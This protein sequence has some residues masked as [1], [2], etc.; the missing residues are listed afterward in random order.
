M[1]FPASSREKPNAVWVRSFVPKEKNSAVSASSSATTA[2]RGSSIIVPSVYSTFTPDSA[3]TS[4][5]RDRQLTSVPAILWE[6]H[7]SALYGEHGYCEFSIRQAQKW[8][9]MALKYIYVFGEEQITGFAHLYDFCHCSLDNVMLSQF[10]P[11]GSP[12]RSKPRSRLVDYAQYLEVQHSDD[13]RL[14][15]WPLSFDCGR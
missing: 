8:L 10:E 3:N 1:T 13:F 11:L 9:N 4:W 12:I 14:R 2:A 15:L 6:S 5:R 7:L